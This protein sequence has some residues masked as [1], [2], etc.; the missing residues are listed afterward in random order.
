MKIVAPLTASGE[1]QITDHR[2]KQGKKRRKVAVEVPGSS[3]AEP[4]NGQIRG[5][6]DETSADDE[7]GEANE[8]KWL[9]WAW[10]RC[11]RVPEKL[12][13]LHHIEPLL[14]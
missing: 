7:R 6:G 2:E 12:L 10:P 11:W 5:R 8:K 4:C 13:F 1:L 9:G 3:S 14:M